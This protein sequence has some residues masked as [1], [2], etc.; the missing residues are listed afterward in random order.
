[1]NLPELTFEKLLRY[2]ELDAFCRELAAAAPALIEVSSIGGSRAGRQIQLLTVTDRATGGADAKPGFLIFGNVH[3]DELAGS[4]AAL[5]IARRLAAEH[6]PGGILE[7]VAFYIVPRSNPDGAELS[8]TS[9]GEIRSSVWYDSPLPPNSLVPK[10]VDGNGLLLTMR[11]ASPHGL[12]AL[13]PAEPRLVIRRT[14]KTSGP[15][16]DLY[17]EGEIIRWDGSSEIRPAGRHVDW[18]RNWSYDWRPEPEQWGAGD[19]P[20]SEPEMRCL[21]ELM[22]ARKNLFQVLSFHTGGRRILRPPSSGSDADLPFEDLKIFR[23]LAAEGEKLTSFPVSAVYQYRPQGTPDLQL[24]GHFHNFGYRHLG[25]FAFEIE[26]GQM[27]DEAE[28]FLGKGLP[29]GDYQMDTPWDDKYCD[30][31]AWQ[32][33]HP[34]APQ[35]YCDW[36]KFLH[37]QLGEVE[38]GGICPRVM[39]NPPTAKLSRISD[40][41]FNF[42]M[43]LAGR[44][45]ALELDDLRVESLGGGICRIRAIAVNTGVLPTHVSVQ[46]R[47]LAKFAPPRIELELADGATLLSRCGHLTLPHLRGAADGDNR[48]EL[49]WFIRAPDELREFGLLRLVGGPGGSR[50]Y[51]LIAD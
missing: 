27:C 20:F 22:F 8:L 25:L 37:P 51:R 49:E 16:F 3:A 33:A 9:A 29:G 17:P 24:R 43:H 12:F 36:R 26:L 38:I 28:L 15:Y 47:G 46:G 18:N 23:E 31:L 1:M 39:R 35:A 44:H 6:R 11:K 2:D 10:D 19:F 5:A 30:V 50:E 45:P 32:D 48:R 40:D 42:T 14:E 34:D 13:H 4:H 21:A 7:R 41:V